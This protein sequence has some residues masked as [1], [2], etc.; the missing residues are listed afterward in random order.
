MDKPPYISIDEITDSKKVN[1]K[2]APTINYENGSCLSLKQ[3]VILVNEHNKVKKSDIIPTKKTFETVYP[4][5]Y[6][7]YLL[8]EL[9]KRYGDNQPKWIEH[10]TFD[11]ME[12]NDR[13][14]IEDFTFLAPGPQGKY[15]WLSNF[16]IDG[17]M[18]QY[19]LKHPDFLFLGTVPVDFETHL[20]E[21]KNIDF[22]KIEGG[23]KKRL[24]LVINLDRHDQSGSHWVSLFTDLSKG[25]IYFSDS[26]G[27]EPN[28]LIANFIKRIYKYLKD[29][30]I[31]IDCQHNK[32]IH[33]RGNTECGV[34]S[35]NFILRLLAGKTFEY[36]TEKI[37]VDDRMKKCRPKYF[38]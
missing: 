30:E 8:Y 20:N 28:K 13:V 1:L 26:T 10:K 33:Q 34:Y 23:G 9:Q 5:E 35:I 2:C 16:D 4:T 37:V 19:Q 11:N 31:P 15:E 14:M 27:M 3:L 7:I 36:I 18:K 38:R 25:Q 6:K 29:K 12:E 22:S 17:K 24:G 21:F 32:N